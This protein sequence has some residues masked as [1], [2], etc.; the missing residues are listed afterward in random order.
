LIETEEASAEGDDTGD[1]Y[2]LAAV[3]LDGEV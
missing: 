3:D 1:G 2:F